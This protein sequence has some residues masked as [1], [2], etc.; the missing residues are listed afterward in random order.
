VSDPVIAL[1]KR[2][3]QRGGRMLSVVDLL[4]GETLSLRQAA[5]LLARVR[6]GSSW[7]VGAKPGGAGKTAVMCALLAMVPRGGVVGSAGDPGNKVLL[8][9]PGTG[10]EQARAGDTVLAY[11]LSPG[12]YDA[13]IWG[14]DVARLTKLGRRGCR[15]V[16]NLH[17]DTLAEARQ[18]IVGQCG[19][20]EADLGAFELFLPLRVGGRGFRTAP[21]VE[22]ILWYRSGAWRRLAREQFE[23]GPVGVDGGGPYR[24]GEAGITAFLEACLADGI[25]RVEEVRARWLQG[26]GS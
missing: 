12:Y 11:E 7:L 13:Y 6:D 24:A 23:R 2:A 8:T 18:Q 17:A 3:N 9:N 25:R 19:A 26:P 20:D 14:E 4:E 1:V 16:S 21:R 10:W 5:W 15:I 22:E